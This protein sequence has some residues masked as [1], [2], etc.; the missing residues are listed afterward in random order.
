MKDVLDQ[1][2]QPFDIGDVVAWSASMRGSSLKTGI[3]INLTKTGR[4]IVQSTFEWHSSTKPVD[5][6]RRHLFKYTPRTPHIVNITK[7]QR[8]MATN[9]EKFNNP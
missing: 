5:Q 7:A 8:A 3:V 1:Y 2:G 6:A 9:G 4:P